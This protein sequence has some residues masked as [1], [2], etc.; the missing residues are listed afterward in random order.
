MK[1]VIETYQAPVKPNEFA[2]LVA[3]LA[4]ATKVAAESG[5]DQPLGKFQVPKGTK[6]SIAKRDFSAAAR[7]AGFSAR[8]KVEETDDKGVTTLG[9]ILTA[10]RSYKPRE[11]GSVEG[12]AS[13]STAKG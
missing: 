6:V 4:E 5:A 8:V 2:P 11:S 3:D 7:N 9:Y 12:E 10:K 1:L 13:E